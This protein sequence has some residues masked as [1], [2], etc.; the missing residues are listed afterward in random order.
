MEYSAFILSIAM[1]T[2]T[3]IN[4]VELIRQFADRGYPVFPLHWMIGNRCSCFTNC[5][6]PAKHPITVHGFKDASCDS[7][8]IDKW[9]EKYPNANWGIATGII[10][11][12]LVVDIDKKTG[13]YETWDMLRTDHPE[14]IET[15]TVSTGNGGRHLWFSYPNG[16]DIRSGQNV[17]GKG[18]DLRAN[19]GYIVAPGSKTNNEYVFELSFDDTSL[20]EVPAWILD[21]ILQP[22]NHTILQSPLANLVPQGSRHGYLLSLAV[23]L[24]HEG[25]SQDELSMQLIQSRNNHLSSGDHP[26]TDLEI[27][28]IIDWVMSVPRLIEYNQTDLGNAERFRDQYQHRIRWCSKWNQWLVWNGKVWGPDDSMFTEKSAH[29]TIRSIYADAT[30]IE[31]EDRRKQ[32]VKHA[33]ASESQSRIQKMLEAA[34]PYLA[35]NP[36]AFNQDPF[37]LNVK[38]GVVDLRT[39]DLMAHDSE[40][41]L[42]KLIDIDYQKGIDSPLWHDFLNVVTNRDTQ[43]IEFLQRAVGYTLTGSTDEQCLFFLFGQGANGKTTFI[44]TLRRLFGNYSHRTDAEALLLSAKQGL[45]ANPHIAQMAGTR[46][47]DASELPEG[48][49]LNEAVIKD[50]TGGDAITARFLYNDPFVFTPTHKL[51][52]YGNHK[53]KVVGQDDGI[54]RRIH[55]IPFT[56]S[57]PLKERKPQS[58]LMKGFHEEFPGILNWAVDGCL[59]WQESGLAIPNQVKV[60]TADYRSDQDILNDFLQER[61]I[62]GH[63]YSIEKVM[64]FTEWK[65]WL[66]ENGE[67]ALLE[68]T[69]KWFTQQLTSKGFQLG[70][71]SRSVILG[72]DLQDKVT[73]V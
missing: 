42:T 54:W 37:L 24:W 72:L 25:R 34:K 4:R 22:K 20:A 33:R 40:R 7:A 15:I 62:V 63:Q 13:G 23:R 36:D 47:V 14:P 51:W 58:A 56:A 39:G 35:I 8:C 61:C 43:M 21:L 19:G 64:L 73:V 11:N 44:E 48:R 69:N 18:I 9:V 59:K 29:K 60:A 49:K 6:K 57:I 52:I 71:H 26:V 1:N 27:A 45:A 3:Q 38:N 67:N 31:D 70:G 12:L 16:F 53:P 30:Y 65:K 68:K 28:Q 2:I 55:L 50:L 17:L 32:L 10:S 41:L 66:Q 46:F 5:T